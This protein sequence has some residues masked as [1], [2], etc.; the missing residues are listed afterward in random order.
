MDLKGLEDDTFNNIY[1]D[2]DYYREKGTTETHFGN[3][4]DQMRELMTEFNDRRFIR[5]NP[6]LDYDPEEWKNMPN[7]KCI[8]L[9]EF[10]N[11]INNH[12]ERFNLDG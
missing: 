2:S 5:V 11:R 8:D 1:A 12:D 6:H 3:W 4:I 10:L 9:E 7:Y